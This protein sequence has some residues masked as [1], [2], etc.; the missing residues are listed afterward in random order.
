MSDKKNWGSTVMGW[1]IVQDGAPSDGKSEN[2]RPFSD[3][4]AADP[5]AAAPKAGG[6]DAAQPQPQIPVFKGA[7]PEAP[8]GQVDFDKVFEAAGIDAEERER[9]TRTQ[10]LLES[11]PPGTDDAVKKQ[12]VMASL[13]AFGVPIEKIIESGAEE[14]Q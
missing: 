5:G 10:Q 9:I 7:P 1:F 11:L 8:G 12:I 2:Y 4:N 14:I 3:V 6:Q 13:K